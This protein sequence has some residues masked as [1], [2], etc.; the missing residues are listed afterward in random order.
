MLHV[1]GQ[2]WLGILIK[3]DFPK[4]CCIDRNLNLIFILNSLYRGSTK[5]IYTNTRPWRLDTRTYHYALILPNLC[6]KKLFSVA[7][8][9]VCCSTKPN[10]LFLILRSV[11]RRQSWA[12]L[13]KVSGVMLLCRRSKAHILSWCY[14]F[15][16]A[17]RLL[18][19]A[20]GTCR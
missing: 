15:W 1:L 16:Y 3:W 6:K 5:E 2:M 13:S 14:Y 11:I 7:Y 12:C 20:I 19:E 17:T 9:F 18:Q 10:L 4:L 8:N